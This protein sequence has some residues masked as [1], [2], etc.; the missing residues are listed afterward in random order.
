MIKQKA[1]DGFLSQAIYFNVAVVCNGV[2]NTCVFPVHG[3]QKI[4]LT[5]GHGT[6]SLWGHA[7][8]LIVVTVDLLN[9][10]RNPHLTRLVQFMSHP[11]YKLALHWPL[12]NMYPFFS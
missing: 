12:A 5:A 10:G 7:S 11:G 2:P 6:P 4:I 9:A 3:V 1:L 8:V